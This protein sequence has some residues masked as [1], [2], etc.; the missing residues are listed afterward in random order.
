M[1]A[2]RTDAPDAPGSERLDPAAAGHAAPTDVNRR[3][4]G[5]SRLF[6]QL[7]NLI[8]LHF[9]HNTRQTV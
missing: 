3:L 6:K 1:T 4:R 8:D 5:Q 2:S 7:S 9:L